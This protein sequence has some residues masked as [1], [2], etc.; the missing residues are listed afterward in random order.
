MP[1]K[2]KIQKAQQSSL[3][4]KLQSLN[5]YGWLEKPEQYCL[6]RLDGQA[7]QGWIRIKQYGNGTFYADAAQESDLNHLLGTLG[8]ASQSSSSASS[9]AGPNKG[10]T[11][12]AGPGQITACYAGTDESGKGDYFGPLVVAGVAVNPETEAALKRLGAV[13]CKTLSNSQVLERAEALVDVVGADSIAVVELTPARYN[14]L[15]DQLKAKK[16]NL[17]HLM[18]Q[19]HARVINRLFEKSKALTQ[20]TEPKSI[21]VDKFGAD[22]YVA[23]HLGEAVRQVPLIQMP[24]A[25]AYTAVAAA[26]LVARAKF[27]Q[28]IQQLEA[29]FHARLPLGAG[30]Q[31]VSAAKQLARQHGLPWLKNVAKFHFKTTQQ[32]G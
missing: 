28:H 5:A 7:Q 12:S 1:F 15:Y 31:V 8:L 21:V 30:P 27:L 20:S 3:Y 23:D 17:N 13:D 9:S 2:T 6:Y 19:A 16:Q 32:L 26:S 24:R 11:N 25:E 14:E 18:G 10:S 22:H 29:E 4:K